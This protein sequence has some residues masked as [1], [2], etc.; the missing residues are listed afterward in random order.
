MLR[1]DHKAA[2]LKLLYVCLMGA[3]L[4]ITVQPQ[5]AP[6]S[7]YSLGQAAG[8]LALTAIAVQLVLA[9]RW[10]ILERGVGL[11]RIMR[12][13]S[14]NAKFIALFVLLHPLLLFL[15]QLLKGDIMAPYTMYGTDILGGVIGAVIIGIIWIS[16]LK[17]KQL[18]LLYERWRLVHLL[19]YL[20]VAI[21]L[22]HSLLLGSDI[23][24][25][26]PLYTWWLLLAAVSVAAVVYRYVV[27]RITFAGSEYEVV[28]NKL[29]THDV[30]TI[31]LRPT[32]GTVL[33]HE[34][35][36]FAFL[37]FTSEDLPVEEHPFTIASAPGGDTISFS[38]KESGDFTA[39]LG[40]VER[41]DM[42]HVEGPYGVF[43]NRSMPGPFV[44]IAG[45]IG[46]TPLMSMLRAMHKEGDTQP[47]TLL[48]YAN[49]T[50][51]DIAFLGE[52]AAIERGSD[53]LRVVHV[54]SKETVEGMRHGFVDGLVLSDEIEELTAPT[55]FIC[56]PPPM[57]DALRTTLA[58]L[59]VPDDQVVTER[60]AL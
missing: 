28:A 1:D 8:T 51:G 46:I 55:Y 43:S 56:G 4:V 40:K 2:T 6:P 44:L 42:A 7:I 17:R 47:Q 48:L 57:M 25:G 39:L 52:L 50:Q 19:T 59:G 5:P 27:R 14:A 41:R 21:G 31:T 32:D 37:T 13:H 23:K 22:S 16:V 49:R 3:G 60:F 15:R 35:G 9:S 33:G 20:L 18:G 12:W 30:H 36:Q 26:R 38:I 11:D 45:G 10:R 24:S 54:L 29:E 53:W 58:E 34:S